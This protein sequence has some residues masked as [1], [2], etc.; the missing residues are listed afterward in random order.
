[1]TTIDVIEARDT[2]LEEWNRYANSHEHATVYHLSAWA[3]IFGD[4]LGYR[5]WL[6]MAKNEAGATCGILPLYLVPG[7]FGRRLVAVPF[8]DRGGPV[9][10][11]PAALTALLRYAGE[12]ARREKAG[13]LLKSLDPLPEEAVASGLARRDHWVHSR[14]PIAELTRDALWERI[15]NKNRNMVRQ[16]QQHGLSAVCATKEPGAAERWHAL[17]VQT[18]HR[19][20]VPPF[21]QR[22]FSLMLDALAPSG[23]I[24]LV[25]IRNSEGPCAATLLFFHRD[26]CIYGYSASSIEGQRLRANDLMLFEALALAAERKLACFDFGSDS[27]SQESLLFF[28]RKWGAEQKIIPVY[29]S[30]DVA[31]TDSSDSKYALAR[32]VF[33]TMPPAMLS[34]IGSRVVRLFG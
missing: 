28:K 19:L 13:I 16:A 33:R 8:R 10:D 2:D 23:R 7:L 32:M 11:T 21:P 9:F 22:F 24:E 27:P 18:Q 5:S 4:A 25:E 34:W 17:H 3:G 6:L 12:R 20:G 14:M 30:Q 29:A 15:G 31:V 1:V 26:T